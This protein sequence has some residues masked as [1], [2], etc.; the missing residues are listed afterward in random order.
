M[1]ALLVGFDQFQL[2]RIPRV[3]NEHV[4]ALAKLA[5]MKLC[6]ENWS[7]ICS[8]ILMPMIDRNESMY[9]E[10]KVS[11]MDPFK[12]YFEAENLSMIR[13]GW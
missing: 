9:V 4:D 5:S 13:K 11:W 1:K 10:K 6:N 3:E 8:I 7:I 2:E 12:T